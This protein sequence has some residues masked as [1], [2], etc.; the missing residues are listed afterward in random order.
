MASR[1]GPRR[2]LIGVAYKLSI[3]AADAESLADYSASLKDKRSV[4]DKGRREG[5]EDNGHN[6]KQWGKK[7]PPSNKSEQ[8]KYE[9]PL[10]SRS[11]CF[12]CS[13]PYWVCDC[14]EKKSLY[15]LVAQLKG[16]HTPT[17]EE[18]QHNMGSL[19]RLNTFVSQLLAPTKKGLMFVSVLI[20][21]Q[22]VCAHL[23]TRAMHKFISEDK[24]KRLGLKAT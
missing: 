13:G 2:N 15:A 10:K 12:I 23:D 18:P 16:Q 1:I 21:G 14:P 24:A 9:K 7:K 11:P 4:Y 5:H 22:T 20:N 19:Q 6:H 17:T 3:D 8:S